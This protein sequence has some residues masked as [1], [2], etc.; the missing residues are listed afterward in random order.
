[1]LPLSFIFMEKPEKIY[2]CIYCNRKFSNKQALSQHQNRC[3]LNPDYDTNIKNR[4]YHIGEKIKCPF[5]NKEYS[6]YGIKNHIDFQ[7]TKIRKPKFNLEN[8]KKLHHNENHMFKGKTFEEIF[9]KE[10]SL[11]IKK[12]ISNSLKGKSHKQT[13]ETKNKISLGMKKVNAGGYR[14]GSGIGKKGY[15]KGIYCDSTYELVYLI[16]CLENDIDIKRCTEYRKYFWKNKWRKYY[17]DFV[18]DEQIV[19]IKGFI[20]E[21]FKA[22]ILY[23]SDIKVL[24]K[25]DIQYCFDYVDKK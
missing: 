25:K 19:E 4:K 12:K 14:K 13:E 10:K 21:Q 5:C 18:V 6:F 7:H 2:V 23:N 8:Y 22:K 24:F 3:K 1:M 11:I 16:Y 9:G 15:Y 17:P 20:T